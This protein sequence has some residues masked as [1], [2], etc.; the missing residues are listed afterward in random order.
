MMEAFI[1]YGVAAIF[2]YLL[3]RRGRKDP[4]KPAEVELVLSDPMEELLSG[5]EA[6]EAD[7]EFDI[8]KDTD[9]SYYSKEK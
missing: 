4:A 6:D 7:D 5:N 3:W 8:F 9:D 2:V 1:T